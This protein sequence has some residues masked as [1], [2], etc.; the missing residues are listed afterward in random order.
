MSDKLTVNSTENFEE[1]H[2]RRLVE[3]FEHT[4][5][6]HRLLGIQVGKLEP[7]RAQLR[8]ERTKELM[9]DPFRGSLHGGVL[10]TLAD[11]AGGLSV[12]SLLGPEDR[13]S[14]IDLRLDYLRPSGITG[15]LLADARVL[16]GGSRV[17][18]VE[19]IIHEGNP[20][21]AFAR[22][23]GVYNVLRRGERESGPTGRAG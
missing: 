15:S 19:V 4:I 7:G 13:A 21:L 14:T 18:M 16:R 6:F 20:E 10:A 2:V 5:P 12:F 1:G 11:A 8:L 17:F 9:G 3:L 23:S 22:A